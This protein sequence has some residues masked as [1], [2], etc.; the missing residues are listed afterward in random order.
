MT[1]I[2]G[3]R[4]A[5]SADAMPVIPEV[6]IRISAASAASTNFSMIT[7]NETHPPEICTHGR[8]IKGARSNSGLKTPSPIASGE[9]TSSLLNSG[10]NGMS[11][12]IIS[13][14]GKK[15]SGS[16]ALKSY[17]PK[18]TVTT[19]KTSVVSSLATGC[20][21]CTTVSCPDSSSSNLMLFKESAI[22]RMNS[23]LQQFCPLHP[24][25]EH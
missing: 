20:R 22:V 12:R 21:R 2:F 4:N 3:T 13:V 1:N 11:P 24:L 23:R 7:A 25:D 15:N 18:E 17:L 16:I 6:A 19:R 14:S 5:L 8:M 9:I 10:A